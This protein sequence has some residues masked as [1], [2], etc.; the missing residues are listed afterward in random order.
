MKAVTLDPTGDLLWTEV[1]EPVPGPGQVRLR[2]AACGV[3]GSDMHLRGMGIL[4]PGY[5]MGHEFAGV[6]DEVGPG[7]T[8]W[9]AGDAAAVYP[10]VPA[11]AHDMAASI[12]GIGCGG[13]AGGLAEAAVVPADRLWRLPAGMNVV[14][15]ALVEPLAVALHAL[16]VAGVT[17]DDAVAVVGAGPIGALTAVALRARGI[18]NVAVVEPNEGRRALVDGPAFGLE[19]VHEALMAALG[20]PPRVVFECAGHPTAPGLA[21]ELVAPSGVVALLGVLSDPVPISQLLLM[22]KEAQLRAS[23]CYRPASFDEAVGLLANG[24]VPVD[25]LVT[26]RRPMAQTDAVMTEL[27]SPGTNELKVLLEP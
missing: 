6:V 5:V 7:V 8:G 17:P 21:L 27:R 24:Q 12:T 1:P 22:V 20:G 16:D 4:P 11:D 25:R 14:H 23:F 19:G 18:A 10:F 15:G 2:V 3:C 9:S 13:P 26:S